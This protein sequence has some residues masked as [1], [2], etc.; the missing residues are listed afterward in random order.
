MNR[1]TIRFS[2]EEIEKV[3]KYANDNGLGFSSAL[4]DMILNSSKTQSSFKGKT[5]SER[6]YF[7]RFHNEDEKYLLELAE[8]NDVSVP[9]QIRNLVMACNG[10]SIFQPLEVE[11]FRV[12]ANDI[13]KTGRLVNQAV[14]EKRLL[15]SAAALELK[16]QIDTLTLAFR[17]LY[18]AAMKRVK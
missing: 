18:N 9:Q 2:D 17:K 13:S 12:A 8:K 10:N 1:K 3:N 14:K 11:E 15:G 4:K 6:G 5:L 7:V 16:D